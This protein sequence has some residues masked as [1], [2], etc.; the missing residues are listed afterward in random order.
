M[1]P[2]GGFVSVLIRLV[3][4]F[5]RGFCRYETCQTGAS[6]PWRQWPWWATLLLQLRATFL[7]GSVTCVEAHVVAP[8]KDA[9]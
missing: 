8:G 1:L 4:A 2:G 6:A 7:S 5:Y 3:I 9:S